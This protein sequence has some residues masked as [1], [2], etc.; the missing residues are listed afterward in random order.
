VYREAVMRARTRLVALMLVGLSACSEAE[1]Q[2]PPTNEEV[3]ATCELEQLCEWPISPDAAND[4]SDANRI[5][6]LEALRDRKV[7]RVSWGMYNGYTSILVEVFIGSDGRVLSWTQDN[8][9]DFVE[10]VSLLPPEHFASCIEAV[11]DEPSVSPCFE[12]IWFEDGA[13]QVEASC[14][15]P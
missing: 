2:T 7:G 8:T 10:E 12:G 5:C 14:P 6:V 9:A 1:P 13:V 3:F 11:D 15:D 4:D